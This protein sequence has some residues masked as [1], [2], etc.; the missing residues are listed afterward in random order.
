MSP[1]GL[2]LG[3]GSRKR[4]WRVDLESL[5]EMPE[6]SPQLLPPVG[7]KRFQAP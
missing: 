6:C 1:E 7:W 3:K 4:V 5:S 2:T